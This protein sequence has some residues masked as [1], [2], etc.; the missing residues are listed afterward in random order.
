[1]STI[2]SHLEELRLL[3]HIIFKVCTFR[4]S[5]TEYVLVPLTTKTSVTIS[6]GFYKHWVDGRS[7]FDI[8]KS[9]LCFVEQTKCLLKD[10][11]PSA[12]ENL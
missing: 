5:Q 7:S 6:G 8:K 4:T 9:P 3:Y 2:P 12:T 11:T 1:M 10:L